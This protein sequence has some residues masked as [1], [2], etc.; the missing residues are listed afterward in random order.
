MLQTSFFSFTCAV[1]REE[2]SLGVGLKR[3]ERRAQC[4]AELPTAAWKEGARGG[5]HGCIVDQG[6]GC[7]M[8]QRQQMRG[9]RR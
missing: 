8:Y 2:V 4:A 6:H 3:E 5:K 9:R 7:I 1:L